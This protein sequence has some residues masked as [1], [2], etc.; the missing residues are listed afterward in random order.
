M[1]NSGL[2]TEEEHDR[3]L[4]AIRQYPA[5]PWSAVADFVGTRTVRQ[6]QTHTQKYYEKI[7]R[8]MRGLRK[9]RRAW[10]R[11][12]HR[13]EDDILEFCKTMNGPRVADEIARRLAGS[14]PSSVSPL[15]S[16]LPSPTEET[17]SSEVPSPSNQQREQEQQHLA[18]L[19][20]VEDYQFFDLPSLEESLDF[21]LASLEGDSDI[22]L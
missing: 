22:E 10:A 15:V 17:K 12:E 3:F 7:M 20:D 13:I 16:R 11:F 1:M 8:H 18:E 6:V 19:L 2:W 5:G 14:S 9:G 4:V 21:F